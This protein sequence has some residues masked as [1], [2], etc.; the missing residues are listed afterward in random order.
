MSILYIDTETFSPTPISY[1]LYKYM[2][3]VELLI[4]SYAL[5]DNPVQV[6]DVTTAH[7]PVD[8]RHFLSCTD[9]MFCAHNRAFDNLVLFLCLHVKHTLWCDTAIM[10]RRHSLPASLSDLCTVFKVPTEITK[11]KEGRRLINLFCK[12]QSPFCKVQRA[13]KDTHSDQ[14]Q[15]FLAYAVNDINAMRYIYKKMPGWNNS[16]KEEKILAVDQAINSRGF[17]IDTVLANKAISILHYEKEINDRETKKITKNEIAT[18][19][20]RDKL[21]VYLL[22]EY[23]VALP[24]LQAS[25]LRRRLDDPGLPDA[26]KQLIH[27]RLQSAKTSTRKYTTVMRGL[28]RDGR[29]RGTLLYCGA[30]RT[31][32]WSGRMFQPH[33]LPGPLYNQDIID[34]GIVAIKKDHISL[35]FDNA[36]DICASVL[37]GLIIPKKGYKLVVADYASIEGRV[38][39]WLAEETQKLKAYTDY[40]TG[41]GYDM[42]TL[43]YATTFTVNP[44]TVTKE[45]RQIGKVLEL[46]LGYAGGVGAFIT[47]AKNFDIDL[48]RLTTVPLPLHIAD[49]AA[50]FYD[51][52]KNKGDMFEIPKDIFIACDGIKRMWRATNAATEALWHNLDNAVRAACTL[53]LTTVIDKIVI[54]KKGAWLRIK[55]PSGR[56]LCYPGI[57]VKDDVITYLGKD[58]YS[59]KWS[60]LKT[61]G[62]KL[63]E[64]I[65]QAVARDIL[66]N[67]M[68]NADKK[69][70][71]II[72]TVHDEIVTEVLDIEK[73]GYKALSAIMID[74]ADWM[75]R[76]PLAATGYDAYRYKK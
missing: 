6:W 52:L 73:F 5:D 61:Y 16:P 72:L 51:F 4:V 25:T 18:T 11:S 43:T 32:R 36:A 2:E 47:F 48:D 33:N 70:Y 27:L 39:A 65:T 34:V 60:R 24:D 22:K 63:A 53:S 26:V 13:T 71:P 8:L 21:L 40:D 29:L 64:N 45:Q 75:D 44:N 1:G 14:W 19:N 69:G 59:R 7:M 28:S 10:A 50:S 35:F 68:I 46:S 41:I 76:L 17:E 56:Y 55:L 12:P 62:G 20:Q 49:K 54:D 57:R 23:G 38:L 15:S 42:Y 66:A 30:D 37:R 31:A 58:Q 74:K 67:G 9:L 3:S